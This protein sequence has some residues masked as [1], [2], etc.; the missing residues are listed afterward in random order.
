MDYTLNH[1]SS[2]F[3]TNSHKFNSTTRVVLHRLNHTINWDYMFVT[4]PY[5]TLKYISPST[6]HN[7]DI[8][9]GL[10]ELSIHL[11]KALGC[12]I[13]NTNVHDTSVGMFE[14]ES[15]KSL[16]LSRVKYDFTNRINELSKYLVV[17][18]IN[19]N[20]SNLRRYGYKLNTNEFDAK[21]FTKDDNLIS[22]IESSMNIY[23]IHPGTFDV[24]TILDNTYDSTR[25]ELVFKL[26]L[27]YVL[28]ELE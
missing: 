28:N 20:E 6:I 21:F 24:N 4:K 26:M 3:D 9:R 1:I 27:M 14:D 7:S 2:Y 19:E 18:F 5:S 22:C 17:S 23:N 25:N 15:T 13:I 8:Q 11:H 12:N 16:T 10:H